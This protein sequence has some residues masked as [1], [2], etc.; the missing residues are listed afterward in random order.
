M[1]LEFIAGFEHALT[2]NL[3]VG[4]F[5]LNSSLSISTT[6]ART[7][8]RALSGSAGYVYKTGLSNEAF[9]VVGL[10]WRTTDVTLASRVII[11][12]SDGVPSTAANV[13]VGMTVNIDG[14]VSAVRG[15][16]VQAPS[17]TGTVLGTSAPGVLISNTWHYIELS[18]TIHSSAGTVDVHIDGINVLSLTSQNTQSTANAYA[19]AFGIGASGNS[20]VSYHDDVYCLGGTGGVRTTRIGP[21]RVT[22]IVASIGDGSVAQFTPLSASDNG[23]MV[24]DATPDDDST[25]NSSGTIGFIDTYNFA[26]IGYT[27][28]VHGLMVRN[29][30]RSDSGAAGIR[31]VTRIGSTNYFSSVFALSTSYVMYTNLRETSPATSTAWTIAEIDAAEFG[32]EHN[33]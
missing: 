6:Q 12:L 30:C 18:A 11:A 3:G 23:A 29:D 8:T 2:A 9:R 31:N 4:Y 15:R 32:V 25:Y 33:S 22:G 5:T 17:G 1:A 14:S 28:T 10:G 19:N 27:G 26:A 16:A 13:Q 21:C 7:G 24:D 20:N